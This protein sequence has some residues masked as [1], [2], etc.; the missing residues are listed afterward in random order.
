MIRYILAAL[1]IGS[2]PAGAQTT[3]DKQM[4]NEALSECFIRGAAAMDDRTSDA[5]VI[6]DATILVCRKEWDAALEVNGR[7]MPSGAFQDF[8][9]L[10]EPEMRQVAIVMV[11]RG[12]AANLLKRP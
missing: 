7:G 9:K 10:S 11:L 8:K 4:A 6:A 12:R 1:I 2:T 3:T 5:S